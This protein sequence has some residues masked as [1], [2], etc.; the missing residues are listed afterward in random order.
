VLRGRFYFIIYESSRSHSFL[1]FRFAERQ[2]S[3]NFVGGQR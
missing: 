1:T 3:W 2:A